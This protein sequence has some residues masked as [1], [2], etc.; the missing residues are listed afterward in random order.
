[1]VFFVCPLVIMSLMKRVGI[2]RGG[3]GSHYE[4]SLE[5]GG[6]IL[7]YIHDHLLGKW[8]PVDIFVDKEGV[9]HVSGVP[10]TPAEL[11]HKVDVV[12]NEA[13]P[14]MARTLS[15]FGIPH[16]SVPAFSHGVAQS[17]EMLAEH[18]RQAKELNIKI[19]KHIVFPVYQEDIDGEDK[20]AYATRRA[21]EVFQ[22]FPSPWTVRSLTPNPNMGVHVAN[23][24]PQLVE[25]IFD[26]VLQ[27]ESLLVEELIAGKEASMHSLSGFRG[28]DVYI[29]PPK[30]MSKEN[31]EKLLPLVKKLHSHLNARH[32]LKSDFVVHPNRGVY[33]MNLDFSPDLNHDS[34]FC[35]SCELVGAKPSHVIEH[36]LEEVMK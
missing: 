30:D 7:S 35:E 17:R 33:L 25:A 23:T 21:N 5:R 12:W 29:F 24:Y 2:L 32:Y 18:M 4:K 13:H 27:G 20:V 22:K 10:V 6:K 1:M 9:W 14:T 34:P 19:P 3:Q 15:H 31:K 16:V 11:L 26:G 28:T 8:K 36:M